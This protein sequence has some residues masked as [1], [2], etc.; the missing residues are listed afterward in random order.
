[1]T[2]ARVP[3]LVLG[4]RVFDDDLVALSNLNR[5]PLFTRKHVGFE[6]VTALV[7]ALPDPWN[8]TPIPTRFTD[9]AAATQGPLA[10]LTLIGADDI[11]SR[12]TAQQHSY[13]WLCVA[14]T[15]H[16]EVVISEHTPETPCAGCIHPNDESGTDLIPTVAFVSL[17]AGIVQA[18]RLLIYASTGAIQPPLVAWPL[19]L[20]ENGP[21]RELGQTGNPA[22]PV[23]CSASVNEAAALRENAR[24]A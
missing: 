4:G 7:D 8:L 12:W 19:G 9:L 17:F 18:H 21:I 23:K 5:Y 22:C 13:G 14:G 3:G 20:A 16:L 10:D 15:T 2:L 1:M 11:P 24:A 6:K